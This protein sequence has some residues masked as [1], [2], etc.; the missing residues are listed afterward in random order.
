MTIL[1]EFT[2]ADRHCPARSNCDWINP[3]SFEVCLIWVKLYASLGSYYLFLGFKLLIRGAA[4][5]RWTVR[6]GNNKS[7][8]YYGTAEL[9]RSEIELVNHRGGIDLKRNYELFLSNLLSHR[10]NHR[11]TPRTS[12]L[13]LCNVHFPS[14]SNILRERTWTHPVHGDRHHRPP[15]EVWPIQQGCLH[16]AEN[17]GP[18]PGFLC[19]ATA[20]QRESHQNVLLSCGKAWNYRRN[21]L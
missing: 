18:Q 7:T 1:R 15:L 12:R 10:G 11:I 4:E 20:V 9:L 8:T 2:T 16:G 6:H 5:V 3:K 14:A 21:T 13:Q 17:V 19:I